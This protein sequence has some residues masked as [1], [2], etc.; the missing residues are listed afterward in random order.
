MGRPSAA[1]SLAVSLGLAASVSTGCALHGDGT[2]SV[3]PALQSFYLRSQVNFGD[4]IV[5]VRQEGPDVRVRSI[6]LERI[7]EW[8][9]AFVVKADDRILRGTS[10]AAVAGVPLCSIGPERFDRALERSRNTTLQTIDFM[11]WVGTVVASCSGTERV[12]PWLVTPGNLI[13]EDKLARHDPDIRKMWHWFED[14][15]RHADNII[16]A[17]VETPPTV[18]MQEALGTAVAPDIVAGRYAAGYAA[19]DSA[20]VERELKGY[21]GP[22]VERGLRPPELLGVDAFRF[23]RY[24]APQFPH[25]A[26]AARLFGDVRLRLLVVPDSGVVSRVDLVDGP[27]LLSDAA[28]AAAR[29]WRFV[30]GTTSADPFVVTLRFQLL[31]G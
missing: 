15:S 23:E 27:P 1:C 4:E 9:P 24:V 11:G 29:Q 26:L 22:P 25:I 2:A 8:C 18:E 20:Y 17:V 30:S 5:D 21:S 14:V 3:T 12:F 10:V 19:E 31:C 6:R 7:D 13:D 16:G 28:L